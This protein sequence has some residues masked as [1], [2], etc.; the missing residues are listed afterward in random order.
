MER[1]FAPIFIQLSSGIE[2][3]LTLLLEHKSFAIM[4]HISS[5]KI[6]T[7]DGGEKAL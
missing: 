4:S 3:S 2:H 5:F 6:F 1:R 7:I